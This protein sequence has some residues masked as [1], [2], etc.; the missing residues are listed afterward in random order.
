MKRLVLL[1]FHYVM[2]KQLENNVQF[3]NNTLKGKMIYNNN[4]LVF[5]INAKK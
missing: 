1:N 2:L 5:F 4:G 3:I